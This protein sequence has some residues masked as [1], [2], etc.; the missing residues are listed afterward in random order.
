MYRKNIFTRFGLSA[1]TEEGLSQVPTLLRTQR[2]LVSLI[3]ADMKTLTNRVAR[4]ICT[5]LIAKVPEEWQKVFYHERLY[6]SIVGCIKYG[7]KEIDFHHSINFIVPSAEIT[8]LG[9][10]PNEFLQ[11]V[12][13]CWG[14]DDAGEKTENSLA[15]LGKTW[16]YEITLQ[17]QDTISMYFFLI[18]PPE[19]TTVGSDKVAIDSN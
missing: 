2:H 6:T 10:S 19:E 5:T 3:Q 15:C 18:F 1:E 9:V 14:N 16:E 13:T 12:N 17:G 4:E 8:V 11:K 7:E